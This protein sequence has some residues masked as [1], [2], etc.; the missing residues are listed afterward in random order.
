MSPLGIVLSFGLA[1]IAWEVF[2]RSGHLRRP[3][4]RR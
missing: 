4:R 3:S 1:A 2:A